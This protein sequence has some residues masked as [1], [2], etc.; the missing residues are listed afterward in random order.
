M[1]PREPPRVAPR[2]DGEA[3]AGTGA[4]GVGLR[5]GGVISAAGQAAGAE[6]VTGRVVEGSADPASC[7]PLPHRPPLLCRLPSPSL[8]RDGR[9]A[10]LPVQTGLS[11]LPLHTPPPP[12]SCPSVSGHRAGFPVT[13]SPGTRPKVTPSHG[14][15]LGSPGPLASPS[16][17]TSPASPH[18][19]PLLPP[20]SPLSAPAPAR[21]PQVSS[22]HTRGHLCVASHCH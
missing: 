14:V 2:G 22:P 7:L 9:W 11:R 21:G 17:C 13:T 20:E 4:A 3:W 10:P 16:S 1:G 5:W 8:R 19:H 15:I 12:S 18:S 6:G